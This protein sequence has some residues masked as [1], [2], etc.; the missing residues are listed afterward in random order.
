[1]KALTDMVLTKD[2]KRIVPLGDP[3][4]DPFAWYASKGEEI[5]DAR[6]S[7]KQDKPKNE[8]KKKSESKLRTP[9]EN[10]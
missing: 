2:R 8:P 6:T 3:D 5:P 9:E 1:M 7:E 4:G 10:K